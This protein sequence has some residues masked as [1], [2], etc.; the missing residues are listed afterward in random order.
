MGQPVAL[1]A[2]RCRVQG[3]AQPLAHPRGSAAT[4][5]A[6][7]EHPVLREGAGCPAPGRDPMPAL[8]VAALAAQDD[9][10]ARPGI[11]DPP[12]RAFCS[13]TSRACAQP[14]PRVVTVEPFSADRLLDQVRVRNQPGVTC[15]RGLA[16]SPFPGPRR[17]GPEPTRVR[18]DHSPS[19]D[20]LRTACA[21]LPGAP[22]R[23]PRRSR[24]LPS[25]R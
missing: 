5:A 15:R 24:R 13:S 18:F 6:Y 14:S 11:D 3:V 8:W 16:M 25:A 2:W 22:R 19:S 20:T 1:D 23:S 4:V 17:C 10:G 9:P 12:A 7:G 21:W